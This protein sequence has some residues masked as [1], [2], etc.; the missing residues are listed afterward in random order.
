MCRVSR[1]TVYRWVHAGDLPA[2]RFGKSFRV[3]QDAA[4]AFMERA[5]LSSEL[6]EDDGT[7]VTAVG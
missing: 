3:P 4:T 5:A 7:G 1:M 6:G 2:V